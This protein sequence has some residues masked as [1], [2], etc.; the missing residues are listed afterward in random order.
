MKAPT[1]HLVKKVS[2]LLSRGRNPSSAVTI[3]NHFSV[4]HEAPLIKSTICRKQFSTEKIFLSDKNDGAFF[5]LHL[6]SKYAFIRSLSI[7]TTIASSLP[8]TSPFQRFGVDVTAE[9][10]PAP[11]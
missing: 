6:S 11:K 9:K 10:M 4:H 1:L 7:G 8:G 3:L 2:Q 5:F